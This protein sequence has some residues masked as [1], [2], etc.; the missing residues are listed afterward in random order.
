[1]DEET[2][3]NA[4]NKLASML[5]YIAYPDEL[6]D[7]RKID[8]YYNGLAINKDNLLQN[9]CNILFYSRQRAL[10]KLRA[11]I[12][13]D[14]WTRYETATTVNAAYSKTE[15]TI[16]KLKSKIYIILLGRL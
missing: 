3:R 9:I 2:R 4:I 1:M 6:F 5:T 15:N 11:P 13:K 8:E 10:G 12:Y 14:D 16:S 7:D